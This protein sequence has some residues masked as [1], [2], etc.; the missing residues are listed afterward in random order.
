M[1]TSSCLVEGDDSH[2][3]IDIFLRDLGTE[4]G[5]G[6][7]GG[8]AP[9]QDPPDDRVCVGDVCVP[10]GAAVS[11]A[12]DADDLD[13]ALTEQGANL[14]G[15]SLAYRPHYD[16]LFAVIEL[17]YMPKVIPGASPTFYGLRF[18][19]AGRSYEVRATSLNFGTFGLFDCTGSRPACAKVADLRG[20]Y[21]TTGMRVVF[22]LPLREIGLEK[23]G[24][25]R[26]ITAFS[27]VG[28]YLTGASKIL[29]AVRLE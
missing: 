11:S 17:E 6:G 5:I 7:L 20:G 14:Y 10:P 9:N 1:S 22:S 13:D 21:G 26:G 2:Y 23:G 16:D 15:A 8:A 25:L 12:D 3:P 28:S 27:G 19:S 4:L 29:D 18:E 24:K